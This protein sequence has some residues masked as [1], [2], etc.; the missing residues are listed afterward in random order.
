MNPKYKYFLLASFFYII[1]G[2]VMVLKGYNELRNEDSNQLTY[3]FFT[4][5]SFIMAI[6]FLLKWLR[7]LLK[8]IIK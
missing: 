7:L 3:Y 5:L 1:S 4:F 2:A 8:K 6:W